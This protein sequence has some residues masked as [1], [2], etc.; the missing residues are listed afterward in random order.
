MAD[1]D[2]ERWDARWRAATGRAEPSPFLVALDAMLPRAG[3]ALD[4]AG[5]AGRNGVWLARRGLDVV[6]A[7]VSPVGLVVA[8]RTMAVDLETEPLPPGPFELIVAID[9]LHRPLLTA[10]PDALAAGG[11]FVMAQ[12]TRTNL[13][14]NAHPSARFL[15]DDGE[16]PCLVVGLEVVRYDEGWFGDRHEARLVARKAR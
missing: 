5:G 16:L 3:A 12:P 13:T 1:G 14:R 11:L 15:L 4:V 2:R 6:C 9:F 7:D 8:L 10:V